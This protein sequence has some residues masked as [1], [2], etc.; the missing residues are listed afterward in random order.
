MSFE[1]NANLVLEV[2]PTAAPTAMIV[3]ERGVTPA[4]VPLGVDTLEPL[5]RFVVGREFDPPLSILSLLRFVVV[6]F[7]VV[8]GDTNDNPLVNEDEIECD[9]GILPLLVDFNLGVSKLLRIN[10]VPTL[11]FPSSIQLHST[12]SSSKSVCT[13]FN[14]LLLSNKT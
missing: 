11:S 12:L 10:S 14:S 5:L 7:P 2:S 8:V 4:V 3:L 13:S 6:R 9:V 1:D